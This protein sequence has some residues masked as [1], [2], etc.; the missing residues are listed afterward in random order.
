[1]SERRAG[2]LTPDYDHFFV[3]FSVLS[4]VATVTPGKGHGERQRRDGSRTGSSIITPLDKSSFISL[5]K[6]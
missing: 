2:A 4:E 5:G 3:D 1:M 6:L